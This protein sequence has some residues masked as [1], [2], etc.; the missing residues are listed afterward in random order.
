[1]AHS[2]RT[3]VCICGSTRNSDEFIE[4]N[5]QET[6]KGKL[7][8]TVGVFAHSGEK[9]HGRKIELSD[10]EK[11][12]LDALHRDKIDMADEVLI[13]NVGELSDSTQ[14][15]LRYA[16]ERGKLIRWFNPESAHE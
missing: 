3:I 16:K 2:E 15:E 13:L 8:L 4:A 6:M 14:S 11:H 9:V 5:L 10:K 7:V 12:E 1:M